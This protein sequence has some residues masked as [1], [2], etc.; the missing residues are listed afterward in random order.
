MLNSSDIEALL[1]AASQPLVSTWNQKLKSQI[2]NSTRNPGLDQKWYTLSSMFSNEKGYLFKSAHF[3]FRTL[4]NL[5][6]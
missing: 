5:L 2:F 3:I 4:N 6:K 1:A